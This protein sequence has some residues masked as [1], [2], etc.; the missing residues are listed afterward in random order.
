MDNV[1]P[2]LCARVRLCVLSCIVI[3]KCK[4][5]DD[6]YGSIVNEVLQNVEQKCSRTEYHH[7][8]RR[9]VVTWPK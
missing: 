4:I 1:K 2:K 9:R 7:R 5:A 3:V 6:L 8:H